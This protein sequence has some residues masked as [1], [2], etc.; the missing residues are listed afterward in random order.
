MIEQKGHNLRGWE[1][2]AWVQIGGVG[3]PTATSVDTKKCLHDC[4]SPM[5][6]LSQNGYGVCILKLPSL[7]LLYYR[8]HGH[9]SAGRS[10][11]PSRPRH[12]PTP[13]RRHGH[14]TDTVRTD[15]VEPAK[16]PKCKFYKN[17]L[18]F[19]AR[20]RAPWRLGQGNPNLIN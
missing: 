16:L 4:N 6:T 11:T 19:L 13:A 5:G 15:T 7:P 14:D 2:F 18:C 9:R 1:R 17:V 10:P 8:R 12:V 20:T 3:P